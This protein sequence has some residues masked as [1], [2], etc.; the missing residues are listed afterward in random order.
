MTTISQQLYNL[1]QSWNYEKV[2]AVHDRLKLRV[3]IRRNAYDNQSYVRGHAF[4]PVHLRW[5]LLVDKPISTAACKEEN[6]V[7]K[8][9]PSVFEQ[10]AK[11]VLK[12]LIDLCS[13]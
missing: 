10:D 7:K 4:D 9:N 2:V 8:A 1:D 6:Y 13:Q 12:E 5:N 11:Q 3:E